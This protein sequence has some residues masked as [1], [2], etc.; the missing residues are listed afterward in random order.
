ME[1]GFVGQPMKD[2]VIEMVDPPASESRIRVR[3]AAVGE[4][5]FLT[6]T[7]A[8]L[9]GGLFVPDDLLNKTANGF[10]IVGRISDVINVAGKKVNPAEVEAHLL[11][12][13]GVRQAVVFGRASTLRNEEVAACVVA[14]PGVS[15]TEVELLEFCRRELSAW[16]VPKRVFIVDAIP[17]TERGKISRRDL[18]IRM[19]QRQRHGDCWKPVFPSSSNVIMAA[20]RAC[21][22]SE[23]PARVVAATSQQAS[24]LALVELDPEATVAENADGWRR[25]S[26][27]SPPAA[28]PRPP[29]TT[30]RALQEGRRGRLRRRRDRRLGRGRLD[31]DGTIQHLAEGAEIVTV[32]AGEGAP[33][34]LVRDRHPRPRRGRGRDPRGGSAELVVAAGRPVARSF[35]GRG[36]LRRQTCSPPRS[37]GRAPASST[38]AGRAEGVGRSPPRRRPRPASDRRRPADPSAPPPR[39]RQDR[40]P[41]ASLSSKQQASIAVEVLEQYDE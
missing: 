40:R 4:V 3:S 27:E 20:E 22:L 29:A 33:I 2:V 30:P 24:L 34:A 32:I 5:I 16:Q 15:V 35:A 41:A 7:E 37:T 36:E 6:P 23:K 21:E 25:R 17:L 8:K 13:S 31:P 19:G 18:A 12:F 11:R 10:R 28:S 9:G 39:H 1:D 26:T 14:L 38:R